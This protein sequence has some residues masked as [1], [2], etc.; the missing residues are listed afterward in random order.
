MDQSKM[1][2]RCDSAFQSTA[3]DQVGPDPVLWQEQQAEESYRLMLSKLSFSCTC[4][5]WGRPRAISLQGKSLF[6][7]QALGVYVPLHDSQAA[8]KLGRSAATKEH[9]AATNGL[10]AT[11]S[12]HKLGGGATL[13]Y[14][15]QA[16]A[17]IISY[18]VKTRVFDTV[19]HP[20]KFAAALQLAGGDSEY[21]AESKTRDLSVADDEKGCAD[22]RGGG[23]GGGDV[24][25]WCSVK[26]GRVYI[27][28]YIY[29]Y[30][31]TYI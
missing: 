12:Y 28:S 26:G 3:Q 23:R 16:A 1:D 8:S 13:R 17:W 14:V 25:M 29:T 31:Y 15:Y 2:A 20:R 22:G 21:Y 5:T 19:P 18:D 11:L 30:I 4:E 24:A 7:E 10:N 27:Y 9:D 6:H